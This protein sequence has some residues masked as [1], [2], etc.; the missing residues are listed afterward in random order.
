MGKLLALGVV[1]LVMTAPMGFA[2]TDLGTIT[3]INGDVDGDNAVTTGDLDIVLANM[4]Q[5]ATSGDLDGD[6]EVTTADLSIL[7]KN[8]GQTGDQ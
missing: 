5:T 4:D 8:M 6:D 1:L 2:Q 7:L 3:L